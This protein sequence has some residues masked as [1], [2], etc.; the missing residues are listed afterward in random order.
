VK[1]NGGFECVPRSDVVPRTVG[2]AARCGTD[3]FGVPSR[4]E[5]VAKGDGASD[6]PTCV[7][8][9]Y[10]ISCDATTMRGSARNC[11]GTGSCGACR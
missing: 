6:T 1:G 9:L 4:I 8:S 7:G 3:S 5:C 10:L 2:T 11:G